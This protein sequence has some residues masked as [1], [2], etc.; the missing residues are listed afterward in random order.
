MHCTREAAT[1]AF[2]AITSRIPS[3]IPHP[4]GVQL[5][6]NVS[7]ELTE[8]RNE[9]MKAHNRVNEFLANW[10]R[11]GRSPKTVRLA[12]QR[13]APFHFVHHDFVI[14]PSVHWAAIRGHT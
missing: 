3:G 10:N 11:A 4:D 6:R 12:R 2:S 1:E 9:M 7:H 8:A 13:A 5:I 14:R